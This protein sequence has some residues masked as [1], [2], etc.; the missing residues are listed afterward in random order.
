MPKL[1]TDM[2]W[3]LQHSWDHGIH[4]QK[5]RNS[6]ILKFLDPTIHNP[7]RFGR[8]GECRVIDF[9]HTRL[10]CIEIDME[11]THKFYISYY[12]TRKQ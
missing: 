9:S 3:Y 10:L 11:Y 7:T 2:Y 8:N 1:V 4:L 6:A 12:S 5:I